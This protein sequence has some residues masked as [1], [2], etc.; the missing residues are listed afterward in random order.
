M[1]PKLIKI[2]SGFFSSTKL[3]II[4]FA[5][6][7][8]IAA[9]G[10][11]FPHFLFFLF[12]PAAFLFINLI[13][14][15]GKRLLNN[16]SVKKNNLRQVGIY[17]IHGGIILVLTGVAIGHYRGWSTSLQIGE[18]E[19][20]N[21]SGK[22]RNIPAPLSLQCEK[23]SVDYY[24]NGKPR[25][26]RTQLTFDSGSD[27]Y[28]SVIS[29]NHPVKFYDVNF[30]LTGYGQLQGE[31]VLTIK[32]CDQLIKQVD[33]RRE[34]EFIA[35]DLKINILRIEEDVKGFGPAVKIRVTTG[36][37][38]N[39]LWIFQNFEQMQK[40]YPQILKEMPTMNPA[41]LSP[42]LFSFNLGKEETYI[43]LDIKYD[44]GLLFAASGAIGLFAGI[45]LTLIF[46]NSGNLKRYT[47]ADGKEE[48]GDVHD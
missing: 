36:A 29:V 34:T 30:Y 10:L 40:K 15:T 6:I 38:I 33:A 37:K 7:A 8:I 41:K 14:C 9:I 13:C 12:L 17:L 4:L 19:T 20:I 5:V 25:D 21:L 42:Y 16:L 18:H 1:L 11:F 3:T 44:P 31:A 48:K 35:D 45:L 39:D 28:S 46:R 47:S 2:I 32:K 43:V 23:F 24:D 22:I 27:S 26:F